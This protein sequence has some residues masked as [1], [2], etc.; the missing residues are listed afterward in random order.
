MP[1]PRR[2]HG[3]LSLVAPRSVA[4]KSKPSGR[5]WTS[6]NRN[7]QRVS[8]QQSSP[9]KPVTEKLCVGWRTWWSAQLRRPNA[10][11]KMKSIF[12]MIQIK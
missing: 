6:A 3:L 2:A 4:T 5:L 8:A 12:E 11:L 9:C 1:P 7:D 10:A